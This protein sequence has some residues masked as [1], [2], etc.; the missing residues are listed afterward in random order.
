ML[1]IDGDA[2]PDKRERER[3]K[4]KEK[5]REREREREKEDEAALQKARADRHRKRQQTKA[6][7]SNAAAP[8]DRAQRQQQ[9]QEKYEKRQEEKV[10]LK[11]GT[12]RRPYTF[13]AQLLTTFCLSLRSSQ[14]QQHSNCSMQQQ[15]TKSMLSHGIGPSGE[16]QNPTYES[17]NAVSKDIKLQHQH[18]LLHQANRASPLSS[19]KKSNAVAPMP[20][21][22]TE[23]ANININLEKDG[24][25]RA[26]VPFVTSFPPK[27]MNT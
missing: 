2:G 8:P 3:E 23:D 1:N 11:G 12:K 19:G 20:F 17:P 27:P 24:N 26:A 14:Q 21:G 10:R 16:N 6:A 15:T 13:T 18:H 7:Y 22:S 25:L 4:E 9:Q 5:E